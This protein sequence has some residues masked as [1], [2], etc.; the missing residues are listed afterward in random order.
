MTSIYRNLARKKPMVVG[1]TK[2]KKFL[3]TLDLTAMGIGSTLGV[4]VYVLAGEVSK[5]VAG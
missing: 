1:E 3:G 5:N 2:L 4:G